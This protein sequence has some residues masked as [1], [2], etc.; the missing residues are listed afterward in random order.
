ME[1]SVCSS[2]NSWIV[3]FTFS[4]ILALPLTGQAKDL[5]P[6][7]VASVNAQN[8]SLP[9]YEFLLGSRHRED[10]ENTEFALSEDEL[11]AAR[12]Q[13]IEDLVLT[14]VLAQEALGLKLDQIGTNKIEI[15]LARK[16]LLAQLMVRQ[17]MDN[18]TISEEAIRAVYDAEKPTSLYRFNLWITPSKNE[19]IKLL[20]HLQDKKPFK[21]SYE[22]IETPWLDQTELETSVVNIV[23]AT[24]IG[25][26]V[27]DV[28]EQDELWK[29]VQVIDKSKFDKPPFEEARDVIKA[30]L[31]QA[32]VDE[33]IRKLS[34]KADIQV[35]P[36][37]TN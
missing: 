26:F 7:T 19:A 6:N 21:H 33:E 25:D 35:N 15:A 5:D 22:K 36:L 29:V 12:S 31:T 32:Q 14:E 28:I 24:P 10:Q 3:Y 4:L 34:M 18:I 20:A 23:D 2:K 8:L 16:T 9:M 13:A 17:I 1:I 30:D 37:H 11:S 27:S